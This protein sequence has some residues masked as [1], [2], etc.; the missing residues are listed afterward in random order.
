MKILKKEY[1]FFDVD[2]VIIK[3]LFFQKTLIILC[4]KIT[5][6]VLLMKRV[7]SFLKDTKTNGRLEV[8]KSCNKLVT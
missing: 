2:K 1:I 7:M 6:I 3:K 5:N 8:K 4:G